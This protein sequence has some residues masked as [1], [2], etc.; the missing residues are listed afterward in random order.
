MNLPTHVV[1][2]A[3]IVLALGWMAP[4]VLKHL[5]VD[6]A[7]KALGSAVNRLFYAPEVVIE[8]VHPFAGKAAMDAGYERVNSGEMIE[9]DQT[10]FEAWMKVGFDSSVEIIKRILAL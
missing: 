7:W 10:A 8:H 1:M 6:N 5:W 2:N 3:S 4:P 9:H